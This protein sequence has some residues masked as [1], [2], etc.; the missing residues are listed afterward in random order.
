MIVKLSELDTYE[1]AWASHDRWKYKKD[2]GI[3]SNKVDAKR[4]EFAITTE[5]MAG[6][7]AVGK[8]LN[9]PVNLDLH[10]GGDKGWDFEYKGLKV[11]VK[12]SKA[13]YLLFKR[14]QDF[15]ADLAVFAR[16]LNDYQIELVGAITRSDFV[17]LHK[18]RNFGYGDNCIV[19]PFLLN[20]V[21][22]FL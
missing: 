14:L 3:V 2:L 7:W 1:I 6:E 8:V 21:R 10:P 18:I 13:K 16:Y 15:R 12:T 5:G 17:A 19:D 20:D 11:D 22:V 4:D 9:T